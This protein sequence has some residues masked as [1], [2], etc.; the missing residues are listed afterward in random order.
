MSRTSPE[1][2]RPI[3]Q[4][5]CKFLNGVDQV[6][7]KNIKACL[8]L[9]EYISSS[10]GPDG[11][12]KVIQKKTGNTLVT[13]DTS[14]ILDSLDCIHPS[15]KI[16]SLAALSQE[17]ESGD[18][19]GFVILLAAELLGKSYDLMKQGF[20]I[21]NIIDSFEEGLDISLDI[22]ETLADYKISDIND[23]KTIASLLSLFI[24]FRYPGLDCYI[25]PQ[26]AYACVQ[27]NSSGIT[28]FSTENIRVIKILGGNFDQTK[29]IVGTV[30]I[31]DTEG[32][33]KL[34]KKAKVVIFLCDFIISS[35]E[36]KNSIIFSSFQEILSFNKDEYYN[37]EEIIREL[38]RLGINVV[39]SSSFSDISLFYMDKYNIM[40]VKVQS[41]FDLKR[42]ARTCNS[43]LLP[44]IKIPN[45]NEIG[46]CE[47]VSV[48]LFGSQKLTVFQ[49]EN[50][51]K[52]IFTVVVRANSTIM[53]DNVE[54]TIYRITSI[55][56]SLTR[57]SRFVPG[58]G[59]SEIEICRQITSF[60]S[61]K[62]SGYKKYLIEKFAESFEIIPI[63]LIENN[64]QSVNKILSR[65]HYSHSNGRQFEGVN[66][67]FSSIINVKQIGLWDLFNSKYWAIKHTV[68]A[69]ITILTT[70]QIIMA[71]QIKTEEV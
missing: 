55:F 56:K 68:E 5:G 7:N 9:K 19:A 30:L 53:L 51:Q 48:K 63:T 28:N 54:R 46:K 18:C 38:S 16:I 45:S 40:A 26:I 2:L 47:S 60:A 29:T 6:L 36:T 52:K 22:L 50:L 3:L 59:A 44:K 57:D 17:Q 39:I 11:L 37:I 32:A 8:I 42:I 27:I 41:K 66:V 62:Y 69:V 23:T 4:E 24:D 49:Q 71:K 61:K 35:T 65:L 67:N 14:L 21:S 43:I 31:K 34:V 10:F 20:S 25:A 12:S 13:S 33:I 58:A 1:I 64:S 15:A 70:S